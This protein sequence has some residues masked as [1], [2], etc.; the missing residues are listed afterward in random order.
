MNKFGFGN[1]DL[2]GVYYDEENRRHLINIR[3][4]YAELGANLASKGRKE[5]ARA[6]LEKAD[7]M[8]LQENFAYGMVS[9]YN[10]HNRSS[11]IFLDACYRAEDKAL[12][13]KVENSVKTDLQQQLKYYN[14]LTGRNAENMSEEKRTAENYLQAIEQMKQMYAPKT[15]T[16]DKTKVLGGNDSAQKDSK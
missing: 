2:K 3:Q 9:R 10:Q 11:L 16:G 1:A 12:A 6:V 5:E 4:A 14:S 8:I 7:K 15:L 13:A